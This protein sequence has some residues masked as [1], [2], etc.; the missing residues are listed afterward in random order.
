[1]GCPG[2]ASVTVCGLASWSKIRICTVTPLG[3]EISAGS[4]APPVW[5]MK[6]AGMW[7]PLL[8]VAPVLC[9]E[10]RPL[11]TSGGCPLVV[12]LVLVRPALT[13]LVASVDVEAGVLAVD[14]L[15]GVLGVA[16]AAAADVELVDWPEPPQAASSTAASRPAPQGA[17]RGIG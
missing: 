14:V 16:A 10:R 9:C 13:V 6:A 12:A 3:A 2:A 11:G 17:D 15:A 8:G 1:V 5:M 4:R 7:T